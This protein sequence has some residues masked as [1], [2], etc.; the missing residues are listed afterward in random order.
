MVQSR[1]SHVYKT[2]GTALLFR[3]PQQVSDRLHK[4][5]GEMKNPL[6]PQSGVTEGTAAGSS[7][8]I[9]CVAHG[10]ILSALG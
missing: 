9:V 8:D 1:R 6:E 3:T 10:H 7:R 5:I 4:L 2:N